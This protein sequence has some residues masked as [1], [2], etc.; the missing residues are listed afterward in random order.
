MTGALAWQV[1]KMNKK[2]FVVS[3][4]DRT[5]IS[6]DLPLVWWCV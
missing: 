4:E 1:K 5:G 2:D 3:E 6:R